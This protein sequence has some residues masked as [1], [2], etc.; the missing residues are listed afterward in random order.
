[1]LAPEVKKFIEDYMVYVCKF[2][3]DIKGF[4]TCNQVY[5]KCLDKAYYLAVKMTEKGWKFHEKE[6]YGKP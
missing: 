5:T 2:C 3:Y 4:T 6:N 1:M